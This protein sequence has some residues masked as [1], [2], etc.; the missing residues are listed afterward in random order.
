VSEVSET[1]AIESSLAEVWDA[2]FD[3]SGWRR[4]VEGFASVESESGYPERGGT[5][6]WR[7]NPAGRGVVTERVLDHEPRRRHRI[8][9]S[10][11]ESEGELETTFEIR[12]ESVSVT[13]RTAYKV[14]HPGILGPLTDY[15][16]VR[17]QVAGSLARS[18]NHLKHELEAN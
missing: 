13:Q 2:Y 3:Q 7:S 8:S 6:R 5:L 16:F 12:G 10:D 1:I 14:L 18:L 9:F 17:R 15:L 11:P 4:W